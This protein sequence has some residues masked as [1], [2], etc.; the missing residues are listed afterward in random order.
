[1]KKEN[2]MYSFREE[3]LRLYAVTDRSYLPGKRFSSLLRAVEQ[4]ILGGV[5]MVQLREKELTDAELLSE[6]KEMVSLCHDHG[7]PLIIDDNVSVC[8]ASG[9][10]G[11]HVGQQDTDVSEARSILG[12]NRILGATAHNV[13]EAKRAEMEGADYLGC[14]AAFPSQTKT[15]ARV[16]SKE[17]YR[18]ITETVHI[19]VCAIG[20]INRGNIAELTGLGLKGV[21]VVSG[22]FSAPDIRTAAGELWTF[23]RGILQ[24]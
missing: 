9:A 19:P 6:A 14:G 2:R 24:H 10:D 5:T 8:L 21:A 4:A 7:V 17:E 23:S 13:E 12:K 3:Y 11:V 20:G 15:D 18:K 22:I 16:L 1:M